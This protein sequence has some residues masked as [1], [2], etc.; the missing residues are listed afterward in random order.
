MSALG[1]GIFPLKYTMTMSIDALHLHV[2]ISIHV[3][4]YSYLLSLSLSLNTF[5]LYILYLIDVLGA[6]AIPV[7]RKKKDDLSVMSVY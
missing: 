7:A 1:L 4:S 6:P 3:M 2:S 5:D